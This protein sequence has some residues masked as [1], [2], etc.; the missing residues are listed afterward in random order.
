MIP[1]SMAKV[2]AGYLRVSTKRFYWCALKQVFIG[3]IFEASNATE[4]I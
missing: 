3:L 2:F 4:R 1:I